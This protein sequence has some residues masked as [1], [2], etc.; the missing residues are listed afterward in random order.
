[1][2]ADKTREK[3]RVCD[4]DFTRNRV[5]T[6]SIVAMSILRGHKFSL[7][8]ALNKVFAAL[9]K[10]R[11]TPTNS[12]LCQARQKIDPALFVYLHQAT[13][14]DFYK[15]YGQDGEVLTWRGHRVLA[16][17]GTDLNLPN[18]PELQKAFSVQRNQHGSECVQ[19]LAGVLYDVRNDIALG[20]QLGRLQAEKNFLLG[21]LW[22]ATAPGDLIVMDRL[23]AD[24]SVI[25][26]AEKT[27]RKVLVRCPKGRFTVIDQFWESTATEQTV[28]LETPQSPHTLKYVRENDLPTSVRVRLVKVLLDTGETEVLLT[29]L[30]DRRR[31]PLREFKQ[32]YHWRW[33][34][35]TFYDRVKNIF[36]VERFSGFSET[37]IKQDFFGVI[38]LATLESILA[39][40]PQSELA[41]RDRRRWNKT[42][43]QV[44][45]AVSYVSLVDRAVQLLADPHSDPAEVLD[46]LHFL[47]KKDPTRNEKGRKF[48]RK[49]FNHAVSL[50]FQKYNKR[51]TA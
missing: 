46:E 3:F 27:R 51:I 17:D 32:V 41:E 34:E 36:E 38:F 29:T 7:Q 1:L 47:F 45:R 24:Y 48:E 21:D 22:E 13:R 4:K 26:Q 37:A 44:N 31:Y 5:L 42:Q 39:K 14:D 43:A 35:E 10:L 8:N 28:M 12:A 15:L 33:S 40:A 6:F 18:T 20:A 19:A 23:F 30:C 25:A 49:K 11:L 9:G 16:Y 50:R 2:F